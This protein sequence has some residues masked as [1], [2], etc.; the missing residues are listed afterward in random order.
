M[1]LALEYGYTILRLLQEDVLKDKIDWRKILTEHIKQY[2]EPQVLYLT[3]HKCYDAHKLQMDPIKPIINIA[4]ILN[5]TVDTILSNWVDNLMSH[6]GVLA[7]NMT[8]DK[9]LELM[10]SATVR[11]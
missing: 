6:K 9:L 7:K 5:Q 11:V 2:D 8:K 4:P 1:K 3:D 10:K